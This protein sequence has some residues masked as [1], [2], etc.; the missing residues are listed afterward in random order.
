M[1]PSKSSSSMKNEDYESRNPKLNIGYSRPKDGLKN[2]GGK[3]KKP[4]EV[5]W[6]F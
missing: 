1:I 2:I 3:V 6:R 4:T 5:E